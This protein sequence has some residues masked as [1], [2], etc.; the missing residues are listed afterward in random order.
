VS[1]D[2]E[3]ELVACQH[4]RGRRGLERAPLGKRNTPPVLPT[5]ANALFNVRS[6]VAAP[7]SDCK[8]A[9]RPNP[10][11]LAFSPIFRSASLLARATCSASGTG[12]N[13]PLDVESTLTGS[14]PL[15]SSSM[16]LSIYSLSPSC[17]LQT[18]FPGR[19]IRIPARRVMQMF[20]EKL[21]ADPAGQRQRQPI[22]TA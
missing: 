11:R 2:I 5:A 19:K 21:S 7:H 15:S 6:V 1:L 20:A 16:P 9:L 12:R 8:N 17:H 22:V 14:L 10:T 4:L 13:S 18:S 3:D